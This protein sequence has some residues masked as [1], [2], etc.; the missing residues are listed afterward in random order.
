MC[1]LTELDRPHELDALELRCRCTHVQSY[2]CIRTYAY[3]DIVSPFCTRFLNGFYKQRKCAPILC[4]FGLCTCI[5][6]LYTFVNEFVC[7]IVWVCIFVS[8][9]L[10]SILYEFVYTCIWVCIL[11]IRVYIHSVSA[12]SW[13]WY[14]SVLW[15][16]EIVI[17]MRTSICIK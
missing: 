17:E 9:Y 3:L 10:Y 12:F 14:S 8:M 15:G 4:T 7:M 1:V 13:Y 5:L 16:C 11:S 6:S 2:T